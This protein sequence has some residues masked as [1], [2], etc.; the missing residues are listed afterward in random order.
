MNEWIN[1]WSVSRTAQLPLKT[2]IML[3]YSRGYGTPKEITYVISLGIPIGKLELL[4][5]RVSTNNSNFQI[6]WQDVYK[7]YRKKLHIATK[8]KN[9]ILPFSF[10]VKNF[11]YGNNISDNEHQLIF[12]IHYSLFGIWIVESE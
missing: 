11:T 8:T 2:N 4:H 1:Q 10:I 7:K 6:I 5:G 3:F 9:Q 12:S